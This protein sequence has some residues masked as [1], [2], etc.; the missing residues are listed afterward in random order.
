M[1]SLMEPKDGRRPLLDLDPS[2]VSQEE[3]DESREWMSTQGD[4]DESRVLMGLGCKG[5]AGV[6]EREV[7]VREKSERALYKRGPNTNSAQ[8]RT[9]RW[10]SLRVSTL[11]WEHRTEKN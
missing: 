9:G 7:M 6:V 1:S 5:A 4:V 11:E 2:G 8:G 10:R 3:G